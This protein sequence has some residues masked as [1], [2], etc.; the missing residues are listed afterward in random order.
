MTIFIG[1]P[2]L[3]VKAHSKLVESNSTPMESH[4]VVSSASQFCKIQWNLIRTALQSHQIPLNPSR[5]LLNP[6]QPVWTSMIHI[7]AGLLGHSPWLR[8][9]VAR[10][11]GG[12]AGINS[13]TDESM[14]WFKG[15][16]HTLVIKHSHGKWPIEIDKFLIKTSI[17]KGFSMA[18]LNNQMVTGKKQIF[19]GKIDGFRRF[20]PT[21]PIDW[22]KLTRCSWRWN[23]YILYG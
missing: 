23:I 15:K 2:T 4:Y 10:T 17:Y 20:S 18:M 14:D 7:A 16:F 19:H 6:I 3:L 22:M 1:Q 12:V 11:L 13:W 9:R 5:T 21:K 8:S